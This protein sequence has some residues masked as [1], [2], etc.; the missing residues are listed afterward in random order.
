[1]TEGEKSR[2]VAWADELRSVH[3]RLRNALAVTQE[4]L[5]S[6]APAQA[7]SRELLLFCHGFC[8]A[9][10]EHH[11]GEDRQLFPAIGEAHPE[12]RDVLR[13]LEQDHSMIAHLIGQLQAAASSSEPRETLAR[14][15]EGIAAIM[16]SHFRY[17]ERQLLVVLQSL[18]LDIEPSRVLGPL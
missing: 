8:V 14:H 7:A 13:K 9:L 18:S 16:E 15:L 5:A 2:L 12:L 1:M 6:G 10:T 11:E 4:A 3:A 17:E